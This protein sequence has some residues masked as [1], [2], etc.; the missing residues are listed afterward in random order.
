MRRAHSLLDCP[1][2]AEKGSEFRCA[3]LWWPARCDRHRCQVYG[4]HS[5]RL[6]QQ[7]RY[8]L[9][10]MR[11]PISSI[12]KTLL[13]LRTSTMVSFAFF[14][15]ALLKLFAV[16]LQRSSSNTQRRGFWSNEP[17]HRI[18]YLVHL[19]RSH[20][21]N[22][23]R[24]CIFEHVSPPVELTVFLTDPGNFDTLGYAPFVVANRY[25]ALLHPSR[26]ASGCEECG[27]PC[28]V[29]AYAFGEGTLRY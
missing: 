12:N 9:P 6:S 10:D 17:E 15:M 19:P 2:L 25:C 7:Q 26:S 13:T 20:K 4:W 29:C 27:N 3:S 21:G 23:S 24:N 18:S 16:Y 22:V 11:R 14:A 1:T 8:S 28:G 5:G